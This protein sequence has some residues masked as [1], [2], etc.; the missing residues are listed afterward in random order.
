MDLSLQ[1]ILANALAA[2][3]VRAD[4]SPRQDSHPIP[5]AVPRPTLHLSR[6]RQAIAYLHRPIDGSN[7]RSASL[8]ADL[9]AAWVESS[10]PTPPGQVFPDPSQIG[11]TIQAH[12][13]VH[14][15]PSGQMI[16]RPTATA[17]GLWLWHF[18]QNCP[19]PPPIPVAPVTIPFPQQQAPLAQKLQLSP[20]ALLQYT[21]MRCHCLA[22]RSGTHAP[23]LV[24]EDWLA[25][26]AP[27]S[28]TDQHLWRSLV[29]LVDALASSPIAVTAQDQRH[30]FGLGYRLCETTDQWWRQ[31]PLK[32]TAP[33]LLQGIGQA[34]GHLLQGWLYAPAPTEF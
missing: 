30:S 17:L 16:L 26:L 27:R 13:A 5:L 19:P 4:G 12:T 11:G 14:S 7:P 18:T 15:L 2:V 25:A 9:V 22:H 32:T 1:G 3:M 6:D 24:P 20:L 33:E 34:L 31:P 23:T 28:A 21:H 8:T 10:I 29:A